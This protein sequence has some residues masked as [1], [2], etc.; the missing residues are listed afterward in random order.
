VLRL[1]K[2]VCSVYRWSWW[3]ACYKLR[4][5]G[6][7]VV[8]AKESHVLPTIVGANGKSCGVMIR[9]NRS[10]GGVIGLVINPTV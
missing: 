5:Q 6:G 9:R 3:V 4:K 8:H 1:V 2:Y 7:C 10:V